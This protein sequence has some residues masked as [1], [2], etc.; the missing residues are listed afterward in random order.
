MNVFMLPPAV[1]ATTI[2]PIA[3]NIPTNDAISIGSILP[4]Y[5]KNQIIFARIIPN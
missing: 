2:N 3:P 1:I 5:F 4:L